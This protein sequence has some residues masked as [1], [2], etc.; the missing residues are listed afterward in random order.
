MAHRYGQYCPLALAVE[1]LCERWTLLVVSRLIDGCSQFNEIH[2]GV[3]RISP[4]LLS[5]RLSRARARRAREARAG[6]KGLPRSCTLTPAG[7]E[8]SP[9]IDALAVWGQRWS[10][11]MNEDD[12]DIA[13][14]AW[15]MHRSI[16][17]QR[18]PAGRTVIEFE[19]T[20]RAAATAG[21]SGS[22]TS[23]ATTT[24]ASSARATKW[25]C[26]CAP[27]CACSSKRGAA[28]AICV[29]RFRLAA[30]NCSAR[31]RC[32]SNFRAGC[33]SAGSLRIHACVPGAS[34]GSPRPAQ[35][36]NRKS[37]YTARICRAQR[38]SAR[39]ARRP[40]P[41]DGPGR[42]HDLQTSIRHRGGNVRARTARR[43]RRLR[44]TSRSNKSS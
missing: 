31:P 5:R 40:S 10:R 33:C 21:A 29:G 7:Q 1:L 35:R 30:C 25:T 18:M 37:C 2:R 24:C 17:M 12:L 42:H 28:F 19:F 8:L 36:L 3:P 34:S 4:S 23:T 16:D 13:F 14:L 6:K 26:R 38:A 9:I 39:V 43:R 20:Q 15:S 32:A 22:C 11:D 41:F 27:I 44:R